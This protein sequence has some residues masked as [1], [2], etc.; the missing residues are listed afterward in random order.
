MPA[1]VG[2]VLSATTPDDPSFEIQPK[3]W[4]SNHAV[5][6][7]ISATE[8]SGLFSNA[9]G[10][11]F[12]TT[13][14]K[15]TASVE[16]NYLTTA[17][18]SN[19]AV[20]LNTALTANGVAWTVNSSGISLNVPAFL[21]TAALSGDT[22]KYAGIGETVGTTAGTDLA[23][24]VNTDGVSI[25]YP[26]WITT[27]RASTDAVGLNTALTANGVAWTVNSSG[28]SLNVPAFL[29]TAALSNHSHGNP[30]LALTNLSGTTASAS[31]G[32]TL[33][34]SA[35]AP[36]GG[37]APNRSWVEIQGGERITTILNLTQTQFTKRPIFYP[38]WLDGE[39]INV[40]TVRLY[41]SRGTG[42]SLNMTAGAAFYSLVN[43]TSMALVSSTT[44]AVSITTSAI[45]SG[46]RAFDIT[47]LS[48][49]T[50]SEGRWVLGLYFSASNNSSAVMNWIMFGAD[51]MPNFVG[52]VSAGTNATSATHA[53]SGV[54]PFWGVYSN[55]TAAFPAN[56]GKSN[57]SMSGSAVIPE[58]Y[59][60]IMEV[61]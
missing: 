47:G 43:S 44:N 26:K 50:L 20:G 37:A 40:N 61:S 18:A 48:D 56:V 28:I 45:W 7:N 14:G 57:M 54:M 1:T 11:S 36:G 52:Y 42:T 60:I 9:N 23:M 29:T 41:F 3:H 24:T 4:N 21:T 19:D 58:P 53:S 32:L 55:S 33:S 17:R 51:P 49:F 10:V 34:L 16:T 5:T 12:G 35:A 8:I 25:A 13:D 46:I 22:T 27:A 6:L 15:I 39:G 38:F 59:V 2:H 30:T 31:N